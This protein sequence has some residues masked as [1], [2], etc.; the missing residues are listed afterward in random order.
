MKTR[1]YAT[2]VIKFVLHYRFSAILVVN[3]F[4]GITYLLICSPGQTT[5]TYQLLIIPFKSKQWKLPHFLTITTE[6]AVSRE[7][8]EGQFFITLANE[9]PS[10]RIGL[11][12]R[13]RIL[14]L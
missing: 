3:H 8:K 14:S 9:A 4:K 13:K 1:F 5:Y 10:F 7:G 2:L 12:A 6:K 11:H